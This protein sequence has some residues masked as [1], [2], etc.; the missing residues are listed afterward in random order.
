MKRILLV[1][2][3]G[4]L[5]IMGIVHGARFF[6]R[7]FMGR[8]TVGEPD[9]NEWADSSDHYNKAVLADIDSAITVAYYNSGYLYNE[10]TDSGI[11][12]D[13]IDELSRRMSISFDERVMPR[14]RISSMIEEGSLPM[15]VS[16]VIT[17]KRER[18]S[19]LIPYFKQK[20]HALVREGI[21]LSTEEELLNRTDLKVGIIRGYIYGEHYDRLI[22]Q[23]RDKRMI[24]EAKDTDSLY[25]MLKEDW[26]QVT[27]NIASSYL[28]YFETLDIEDVS[29]LDWAPE[30]EPLLRCI[31]LSKRYFISENAERVK[32]VI[33][34]MKKDGTLF[35][36]FN[37]YVPEDE[38]KRMCDF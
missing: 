5:L 33:D 8:D 13:V 37:R 27:F 23:L 20:N 7:Q 36:I 35:K 29:F 22:E 14:A 2:L 38:A 15:S 32:R 11:N 18:Y 19:Y 25:K 4:S 28:Y 12:K 1:L 30:E 31:T 16:S 24:V 10:N 17:P 6:D 34:E 9:Q 21:G 26:I 3:C